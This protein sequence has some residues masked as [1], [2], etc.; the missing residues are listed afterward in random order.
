MNLAMA[1]LFGLVNKN[2]AF[3]TAFKDGR[4]HFVH[5]LERCTVQWVPSA[6][7]D[8]V[9]LT[10]PASDFRVECPKP[11]PFFVGTNLRTRPSFDGHQMSRHLRL[12]V[13]GGTLG[14]RIRETFQNMQYHPLEMGLVKTIEV[15]LTQG[16]NRDVLCRSAEVVVSLRFR[17]ATNEV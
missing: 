5:G 4:F 12:V 9:T 6:K 7:A 1:Q 14:Q 8:A 10:L 2:H 11:T 17:L 13:P 16:E 3:S 15:Y